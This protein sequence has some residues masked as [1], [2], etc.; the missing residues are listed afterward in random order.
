VEKSGMMLIGPVPPP[1]GGVTIHVE[2]LSKWLKSL[3][4]DHNH[5]DLRKEGVWKAVWAITKHKLCHIH[6]S[7]VFVLFFLVLCAKFST[8]ISFITIHG[9]LLLYNGLKRVFLRLAIWLADVPILLN[10]SSFNKA[11]AIN[12]NAKLISS[13]ILPT[14]NDK[15]PFEMISNIQNRSI[16]MSHVV[17]TNA[18]DYAFDDRGREIYGI[19]ELIEFFL[20]KKILL[21][22]SDP[23]GNYKKAAESNYSENQ[24]R[25]VLFLDK[26][27][28]FFSAIDFADM[29]IRNTV[30]DGDSISIHEALFLGKPVWATKVVPR[31]KHVF[32]YKDLKEISFDVSRSTNEYDKQTEVDKLIELY[33]IYLRT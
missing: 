14:E 13:F 21:I 18:Y 1:V 22:V 23:S 10:E 33:K 25:H 19:F 6:Q 7:N 32:L 5:Y 28:S 20:K 11:L 12:N 29:F 17:I 24:L 8:T 31:P 3:N 15:L 9:D 26:P 27:H 4:F 30:T 16:G 2:R